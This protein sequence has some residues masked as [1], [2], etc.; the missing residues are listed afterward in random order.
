MK[1]TAAPCYSP[2][3]GE[4]ETASAT[5]LEA[6]AAGDLEPSTPVGARTAATTAIGQA[7]RAA[8]ERAPPASR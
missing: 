6:S 7:Q 4:S 5:N 3:H 8:G 2:C 1:P